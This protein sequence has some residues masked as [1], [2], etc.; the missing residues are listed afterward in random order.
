MPLDSYRLIHQRGAGQDG[1]RYQGESADSQPVD[2]RVLLREL[3][4]PR[5]A[6]I[7]RRLR[8]CE[9]LTHEAHLPILEFDLDGRDPFVV[10][11]AARDAEVLCEELRQQLDMAETLALAQNVIQLV[12]D[13]HRVGMLFGSFSCDRISRS[14]TT[15][16][17]DVSG[18]V[19]SAES[20]KTTFASADPDDAAG[21][22][23]AFGLWLHWLVFGKSVSAD[24]GSQAG[25]VTMEESDR[26]RIA[27]SDPATKLVQQCLEQDEERRTTTQK[28]GET[29][30]RLIE[31][32]S[33][34]LTMSGAD[35]TMDQTGI[36][37]PPDAEFA[38]SLRPAVPDQLGRYRVTDKLGEGGMG[39][40]YRGEDMSDGRQVAIK[41]LAGAVAGKPSIRRRFFKEAR[42][43]AQV[44]N[45]Y[46]TN[47]LEFNEDQ[48]ENYIVLEFVAG[49]S[50]DN[51]LAEDGA[52][53]EPAA[54]RILCDVARAL[55]DAHQR[56]IVDRDF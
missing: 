3:S 16:H 55:L 1:A 7:G 50:L 22:V 5:R 14:N 21:D 38:D 52:L 15:W 37:D 19:C 43:L 36:S 12:K 30:S 39:V 46:I 17:V 33:G 8:L 44:N 45:P 31:H 48:G 27:L 28:V 20:A 18:L 9:L 4:K 56:G 32:A 49:R 13:C 51:V 25:L 29:L 42:I 41:V 54:I 2:V 26:S 10:I 23:L 6:E 35:L 53:P 47:L 11:T 34:Q 40:V 24:H